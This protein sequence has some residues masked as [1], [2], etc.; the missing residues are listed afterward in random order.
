MHIRVRSRG[1]RKSRRLILGLALIGTS[2]GGIDLDAPNRDDS[3]QSSSAITPGTVLTYEAESLA[4]TS[5]AVGSKVTSEAAAS[6]G[7]Y[8]EFNGT[9]AAGAWIEFTL[10]NVAAGTYDLKLLYKANSN[11]GIVQASVDGVNQG[12]TCNQ[13][14]A[15]AAYK[16]ACSLGTKA[17]TA[18]NHKLRFTVTGKL[19]SSSGYQM[20]VD[21]IALTFQST[22][23]GTTSSPPTGITV[24]GAASACSGTARTLT[25]SGG[26]L[27]T[28]ASWVWYTNSAHSAPVATGPSITASPTSTTTYYVRAEGACGNTADASKTVSVAPP[29]QFAQNPQSY[30]APCNSTAWVSFTAAPS[31]GTTVASVQWHVQYPGGPEFVPASTD[32]YHI[33]QNTLTMQVAPQSTQDVWCTITDNCGLQASSTHALLTV[34]DSTCDGCS[35]T[36]AASSPPTGIAVSGT[37]PVCSGVSRTLT[38]S[39]GSLGTGASWV[40]YA[41]SAHTALVGKGTSIAVAPT[42]T[43]TYFVRAEG[44]CGVTSDASKTVSVVP[45]PQFAQ[46]PQSYAAPCNSTAWVS[47]TAAPSSGTM[48]SS[49]QWHVQYPGGTEFVPDS[50]DRYHTGQTT[51]N[52][53]VAPQNTQYVWCTITDICGRQTSSSQ[54]LLTVPDSST[55]L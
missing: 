38:V 7:Q 14:A 35:A 37:S 10:A 18:G 25:V 20:V 8:V 9:A 5:S 26:A 48:V 19:A 32:R 11:R 51:L 46:N 41:D 6:G 16:V 30:A 17:L 45:P 27:G 28:G 44:P 3:T 31:S 42:S 21:Q 23:S 33:G 55:C 13:Y 49:V 24:A 15:A 40:W 47:F 22:C 4:R 36:G 39:G 29:P 43:T 52:L 12:T 54:A 50:N 34:P 1:D 2:C 53:Q